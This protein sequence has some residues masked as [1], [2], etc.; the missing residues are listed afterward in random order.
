MSL[1]FSNLAFTGRPAVVTGANTG[2]GFGATQRLAAAGAKVILAVRD[3]EKGNQAAQTI[4]KDHPDA[5]LKVE[6]IDL[7][8]L[9]SVK[10]FV[11]RLNQQGSPIHYL[12]NNAGV[13]APP[14]PHITS[15]GFELQFGVNYLGYFALTA[16][17][18]P[19]LVA[20]GGSRVMTMSSLTNRMGGI[21][22][23]DLQWKKSYS[24]GKSYVQSKLAMLMFAIELDRVSQQRGWGIVSNSAH[25]DST[26]TNLQLT[27]PTMG[28]GKNRE[29]F[30]TR[31]LMKMPGLF[32]PMEQGCLPGLYAATSPD[33]KG[34]K[35]YGPNGLFELYGF[36]KL[37]KIPSKA[38]NENGR[39]RLWQLSEQL[40]QVKYY[41]E[42]T[43]Y[44]KPLRETSISFTHA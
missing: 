25:P 10:V 34:G 16:G 1:I 35:Y 38:K 7:A 21:N 3:P 5:M 17:L 33:A 8:D 6:K 27:G 13:M 20:A 22:F 32:Q 28:T 42:L 36:P 41:N 18:M 23:E 9:H 29:P 4:Q 37:A 19:L 15:D 39:I 11:E 44:T 2:L 40:T 31:L 24:A 30:F 12:L 43:K 26:L 14:T